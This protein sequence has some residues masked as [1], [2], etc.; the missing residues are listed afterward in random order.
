MLSLK[1]TH[2]TLYSLNDM[3]MRDNIAEL[4]LNTNSIILLNMNV[5]ELNFIIG[6]VKLEAPKNYKFF[7]L[8]YT[9]NYKL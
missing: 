5:N 9:I 3:T 1:A 7:I 4:N 6:L 2:S 8:I